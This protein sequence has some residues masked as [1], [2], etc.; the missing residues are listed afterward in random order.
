MPVRWIPPSFAGH[1]SCVRPMNQN[2]SRRLLQVLCLRSSLH[3]GR[4]R[5]GEAHWLPE[6]CNNSGT[7]PRLGHHIAVH[8]CFCQVSNGPTLQS[9]EKSHLL[10]G[11]LGVWRAHSQSLTWRCSYSPIFVEAL[12]PPKVD[13]LSF[14]CPILVLMTSLLLA[15]HVVW[16]FSGVYATTS[17][18][19]PLSIWFLGLLFL[20]SLFFW[21]LCLSLAI[22]LGNSLPWIFWGL[23]KEFSAFHL[24]FFN[25]AY[26][27][28]WQFP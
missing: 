1:T 23:L 17:P 8:C 19:L 24:D 27:R 10:D 11:A 13:F 6:A 28:Y 2:W 4:L 18:L 5:P 3:R 20:P 9:C 21:S 22:I 16:G 14:L 12:K 15:L 25:P 26:Y 7:G